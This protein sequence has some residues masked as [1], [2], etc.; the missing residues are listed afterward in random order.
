M[1]HVQSEMKRADEDD[2]GHCDERGR[3]PL[4]RGESGMYTRTTLAREATNN[5]YDTSC[6]PFYFF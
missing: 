4:Q 3:P 2:E 5:L 1:F 6:L